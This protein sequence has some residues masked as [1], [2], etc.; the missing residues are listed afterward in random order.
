[1][2]APFGVFPPGQIEDINCPFLSPIIL[3]KMDK[4]TK[5]ISLNRT[6]TLL[7]QA[8]QHYWERP[9]QRGR[10]PVNCPEHAPEKPVKAPKEPPRP[11]VLF[12]QP[13]QHY[14]ERRPK[15]GR[16]PNHCPEHAPL[17]ASE[18][19]AKQEAER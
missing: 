10:P 5:I 13:G 9:A 3:G 15:K 17:S 12:C 11:I 19:K 2:E 4:R 1:D 6:V 7:C 14:W 16:L 8:G 18:E